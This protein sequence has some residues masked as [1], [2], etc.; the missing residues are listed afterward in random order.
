MILSTLALAISVLLPASPIPTAGSSPA[1]VAPDIRIERIP[2]KH[3]SAH[4][5][6]GLLR[7][8]LQP[9]PQGG[10]NSGAAEAE[11]TNTLVADGRTNALLVRGSAEWIAAVKEGVA[12][13][14]IMV[15]PAEMDN[16][17]TRVITLQHAQAQN[18]ERVILNVFGNNRVRDGGAR[19]TCDVHTNRV[20][21]RSSD[22]EVAAMARL[23]EEL[24]KKPATSDP[25]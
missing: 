1:T 13:V 10:Q 8:L 18:V 20:V 14:D 22:P 25:K 23:V 17:T 12:V 19:A 6:Q 24:D 21:L 16:L 2:L 4:D 9:K 7:Q 5:A 11:P 15:E 3:A